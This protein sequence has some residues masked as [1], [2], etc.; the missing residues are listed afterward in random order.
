MIVT[1]YGVASLIGRTIRERA[2]ALIDI[3]HPDDR[4]E[5]VRQAKDNHI[6]YSDQI[7]LAES[8][9]MYPDK[10]ACTHTFKDNLSVSFRA[11]KPSDE[12]AMRQL[13]YRFSDK[14]VYY[15]Y[16]S[17]IKSMPHIKLQGTSTSYYR[18]D[19]PSWASLEER[20]RSRIIAEGRYVIR[21]GSPYADTAFVVDDAY[22]GRGVGSFLLRLLIDA[23]RERGIAGFSADVLAGNQAIIRVF[24]NAKQPL[25]AYMAHGLYRITLPFEAP[26]PGR[27]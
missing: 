5:L 9:A 14:A 10:L 24:E 8:G 26:L 27:H 19:L 18:H 25:Q 20:G 2:L 1:E 11:I 23:A 16:F 3:A 13:F 12:E 22:Q 6:L 4:A 15:R 21:P 17:E 7:Y